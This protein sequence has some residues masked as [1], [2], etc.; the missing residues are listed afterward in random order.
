MQKSENSTTIEMHNTSILH[1][2]KETIVINPGPEHEVSMIVS[3]LVRHNLIFIIGGLR[4]RGKVLV[5]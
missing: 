4:N 1:R 5:V 3:E 2:N